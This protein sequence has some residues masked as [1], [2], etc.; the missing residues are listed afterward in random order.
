MK[1]KCR[2]LTITIIMLLMVIGISTNSSWGDTKDSEDYIKV[3]LK[4]GSSAAS[5]YTLK[6]DAGFILGT[7]TESGFSEGMPLPAYTTIIVQSERGSIVITDEN[8]TLLTADLSSS[9]CIMPLDYGEDGVIT[10]DNV[11]YRGGIMLNDN[12]NGTMNAVNFLL[13]EQYLYGVLNSELNHGNPLEAL[14]AQ[15]V[16]ARSYGSLSKGNHKANGFDVCPTTHCQV[17]KGFSGE[18][19]ETN[20]AVDETIGERIYCEGTAVPAFYFKNSGGNTQNVEDVWSFSRSY[21]RGVGDE[22]SP[23]YPWTASLS[24]NS[25]RSK[26]EASGY[27]PGEIKNVVIKEKNSTG[28]VYDLEIIG[29]KNTV[30]LQK[31]KIRNVLGTTVIKSLKFTISNEGVPGQAAELYASNGMLKKKLGK[32]IYVISGGGRI[33]DKSGSELYAAADNRPTKIMQKNNEIGS[34]LTDGNVA[35]SGFGYGH[36]VGMPQDSAVIMAKQG[37]TY[38]EILKKYYTNIE[39]K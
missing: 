35:F 1:I 38:D 4:Y 39:V 27:D 34:S 17:Y 30:N 6:A 31:E 26:L 14:K 15:A 13:L 8:G 18:Y 28:N 10:I 11:P 20:Q 16:A 33:S 21:L 36:G 3:G 22:Y 25:I 23:S 24:Y 29:S 32:T 12:S 9:G 37:F 7:V 19:P 2:K 5:T